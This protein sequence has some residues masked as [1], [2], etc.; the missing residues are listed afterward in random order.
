LPYGA[1][2]AYIHDAGFGGFA[3]GAAPGLLAVLRR[4]GIAAG[5]VVDLGCGSGVWAGEL[6]RHGYE[7]FGVDRSQPFLRIARKKA[8]RARFRS[9]SL[10]ELDL[11]SCRDVTA[12]GECINYRSGGETALGPLFRR[13]RAALLPGGL[14]LFDAASP[15]R[16]P[17][18]SPRRHWTE[19][20]DWALLV[21]NAGSGRSLVR[22]IVCFR[23]VGGR[24][25]R[26]EEKH[27][28]RL[29]EPEDVLDELRR[30]GFRAEAR[31]AYG[32]FKLPKGI[33]AYVAYAD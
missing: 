20:P 1:D 14:L 22:R 3:L 28:L 5:L 33:V 26:T 8:P 7:V 4:Q 32:K 31:D 11:P 13:L 19:G 27:L 17:G 21:E 30:A 2:L 29:F 24:Y 16:L 25:R 18:P 15:E 23:R 12:V 10:W 6:L 9:A